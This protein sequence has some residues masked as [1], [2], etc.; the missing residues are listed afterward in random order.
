MATANKILRAQKAARW[1]S[2]RAASRG[3]RQRRAPAP[4]NADLRPRKRQRGV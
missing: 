4:C 3:W 2:N 1:R